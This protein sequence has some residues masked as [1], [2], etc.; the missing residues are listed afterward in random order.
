MRA[1]EDHEKVIGDHRRIIDGSGK[2]HAVLGVGWEGY[3]R[4]RDLPEQGPE[5]SPTPATSSAATQAGFSGH[6]WVFHALDQGKV[7]P[8]CSLPRPGLLT[9]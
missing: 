6:E 8:G 7:R 4:Q 1:Q 5:G 9:V 3:T 2:A